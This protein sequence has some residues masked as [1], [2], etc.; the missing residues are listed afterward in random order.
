[1]SGS[2]ESLPTKTGGTSNS[3]HQVLAAANT[4]RLRVASASSPLVGGCDG[5]NRHRTSD[6]ELLVPQLVRACCDHVLDHGMDQVGI[7]RVGTVKRRV[8]QVD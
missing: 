5:G 2:C 1:M 4:R 7:F 6:D 8:D 3:R